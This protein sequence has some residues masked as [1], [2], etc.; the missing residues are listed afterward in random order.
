MLTGSEAIAPKIAARWL[1][2]LSGGA[3]DR[4]AEAAGGRERHVGHVVTG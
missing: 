2:D 3:I 4:A 1:I